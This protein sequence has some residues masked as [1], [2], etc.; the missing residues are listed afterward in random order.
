MSDMTLWLRMSVCLDQVLIT[1]ITSEIKLTFPL[2]KSMLTGP[3]GIVCLFAKPC[4]LKVM[5]SPCQPPA[6]LKDT[7]KQ[8]RDHIQFV[9]RIESHSVAQAGLECSGT[10]SAHCS[11]HLLGSSDSPASATRVAG[12]A[13]TGFHH[14]GQVGLEL[15][16]S[17][18]LPASASQSAGITGLSHCTRPVSCSVTQ[19]GVQCVIS[20]HR[21]LASWVQAILLPQPPDML[22]MLYSSLML[23]SRRILTAF[24]G[25]TPLLMMVTS[26][27]RMKSLFSR[28]S[29]GLP[30]AV[31]SEDTAREAEVV[32][33][34]T[35]QLGFTFLTESYS[36]TQAGVQWHHLGSLQPLP[37]GFKQ[38]SCLSLLS[39]WDCRH[40][41]SHPYTTAHSNV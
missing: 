39:S 37:P 21:N 17:G 1:S 6:E 32:L 16:T 20:A 30:L 18:D 34:F 24:R 14:V 13:D 27:G 29:E 7:R 8:H 2:K 25:F 23:K 11:L 41:P 31:A 36:V 10:I 19:A 33:T 5:C 22:Q 28:T 4:L 35:D 40:A 12:I 38:F 9:Q 3:L 15:L 26:L